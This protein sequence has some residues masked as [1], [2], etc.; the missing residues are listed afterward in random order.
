MRPLRNPGLVGHSPGAPSAPKRRW[1]RTIWIIAALAAIGLVPAL[2]TAASAQP[3]S[4][5]PGVAPG[6]LVS[7]SH[8]Y[9]FYTGTDG[10]VWMGD[11]TASPVIPASVGGHLVSAPAPVA[12]AS[13]LAV[14]GQGT[15]NQL[16]WTRQTATGW[17][18]WEPLGGALTSKP[19]AAA[20]G[21]A[22]GSVIAV[23]VRGADGAVWE[24]DFSAGTWQGWASDGGR[25]L[26]G[27]GPAAAGITDARGHTFVDVA[28]AGANRAIY[29]ER[30]EP[31]G[32][33][34]G[35]AYAGGQTTASPA[36]APVP[37]GNGSVAFVRGTNNAGYHNAGGFGA[38][39]TWTPMGGRLSSA[40]GAD[41]NPGS[42]RS[43]VFGLGTDGQVYEFIFGW[44][45]GTTVQYWKLV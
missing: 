17:T 16:W 13:G 11:A 19:G 35:W 27:T 20:I 10:S 7:G 21:G 44:P 45:D 9:F 6:A 43:Y 25:V 24:R 14:F 29:F 38:G 40:L 4:P 1:C 23:F 33:L 30:R 32:V 41:T 31:A 42:A 12:T 26:A 37:S 2:A 34:S 5:A 28:V 18:A 39:T 36:L 3:P 22:G 8:V 15:D